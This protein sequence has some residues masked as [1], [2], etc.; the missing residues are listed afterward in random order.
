M[1]KIISS[2]KLLKW[3]EESDLAEGFWCSKEAAIR[4][5]DN[6]TDAI[7]QSE[8]SV[9]PDELIS[10]IREFHQMTIYTVNDHWCIQLFDINVA[11]NDM[12]DC[13]FETSS[14]ELIKV[15]RYALEWIEE[16][17]SQVS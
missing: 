15:L 7:N 2:K 17:R 1:D 14:T 4:A 8:L 12:I 3:L 11:A 9:S 16:E 10:K 5:F 13:L 6:L